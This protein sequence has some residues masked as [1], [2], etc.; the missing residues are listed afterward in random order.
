MEVFTLTMNHLKL[1][2]KAYV[3]WNDCEY[4]APEINPK[5]PYGNSDVESDIVRIL[6]WAEETDKC[7]HCGEYLNE[8]MLERAANIHRE[9]QLA[10]EIILQFGG[11]AG[12]GRYQRKDCFHKWELVG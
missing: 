4:G 5:R 3:S 8:D 6:G 12:A 10:L 2:S 9:T 7:P 1:L 11:S